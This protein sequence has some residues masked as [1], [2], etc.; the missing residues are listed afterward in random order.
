MKTFLMSMVA[1]VLSFGLTVPQPAEAKRFGGGGSLGQQKSMPA[2]QR[3]QTPPAQQQA[4]PARQAA[5]AAGAAAASGSAK[6][7]GPL[8]G[9]AAGGLLA[10]MIFGEG[11]EGFQIMD[12]LLIALLI[13]G[14][15]MF[16]RMRRRNAAT[17]P[18]YAGAEHRAPQA[19]VSQPE[20]VQ[21]RQASPMQSASAS[22]NTSG[23]MI[24]SA[25]GLNAL[26]HVESPSWFDAGSFTE[27]AKSHFI[28]IQKA[29]DAA[30]A[31]EIRS[32]CTAELFAELEA[33]MADMQPGEN[34]T[35]VDT[36]YTEIVDQSIDGGFF[37]VS[38]RFSGFIKESQTEEAHAFNE[39]WHIRRLAAGEGNWEIAGIQQQA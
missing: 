22:S 25:L 1:L 8:A 12:F 31:T 5:P 6:W 29:W 35:E 15:V 2:Q 37:V 10:W 9:L 30:D 11:F 39:I 7:L 3:Q 16:L 28:A 27:G 34:H 20:T 23:S 32:Y 36:L 33:M 14:V 19:P 17:E 21:T 38:M 4:V 13:L 26:H 24:G 18:A